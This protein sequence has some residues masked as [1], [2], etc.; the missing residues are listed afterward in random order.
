MRNRELTGRTATSSAAGKRRLLAFALLLV[1]AALAGGSY[2]APRPATGEAS[3]QAP[4]TAMPLVASA[5]V[6][7][8][9]TPLPG[10]D[11]GE[12]YFP[13]LPG[14]DPEASISVGDTSHGYLVGGTELLENEALGILPK[15][16]KRNL[17]YGSQ[18][19]VEMLQ[20]AG[21]ALYKETKTRLWVG[22]VGKRGGGDITWSV[23]HNSGRDADVAF[24]YTDRKGT[25]ID[26]PDLVALNGQ[27]LAATHNLKLDPKR[28]WIVVKALLGYERAQVQYLFVAEALKTQVLMFASQH[29]ESPAL[30]TRAAAAMAQP[31]GSAPHNDHLHLRIFCSE[32]DVLGGCTNTGGTPPG[33]NLFTAERKRFVRQTAKLLGRSTPKQ[34]K[35]AIERL[36]LLDAREA[37]AK[38]AEMLSED[39]NRPE[40]RVA[41][42]RS[43]A[44]LGGP[45]QVPTLTKHFARE[46]SPAVR[47]AITQSIGQIG[48]RDA[49]RFLARAV[50]TPQQ[51]AANVLTGVSA[52]IDLGGPTL[53]AIL[54][55]A[56][57]LSRDSFFTMWLGAA[58][59]PSEHGARRLQA[60]LVAIEAAAKSERLEPMK[61]LIALLADPRPIVRDRAAYALRMLTNLSYFTKWKDGHEALLARGRRRWQMA[62]QASKGSPRRAWLATGFLAAGY[63]VP[64]INQRR[65]WELVRAIAGPERISY[66]AQRMLMRLL[67]HNPPSL[68]WSRGAACMHW[69]KWV[70][71]RRKSFKLEK[72]P[73]KVFRAC[74][75]TR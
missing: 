55:Q 11:S 65:T 24:S 3:P 27:G 44:R 56:V 37:A 30:I 62:Y 45:S 14:E 67:K 19:L 23:S 10:A 38:I 33:T 36:S 69:F 7:K 31:H 71:G 20:I 57:S 35:R 58:P 8:E 43:L 29:G 47:I 60:Q 22:N 28:T 48:G 17:R 40:V 39:S 50:G 61:R 66:N 26:P 5:A 42:A 2:L 6:A 41:A 68:E 73:S 46:D 1:G 51:T 9:R 54:P 64:E 13:F 59:G 74:A 21:R 49:G 53:L 15:Q 25:P 16:K 18:P 4:R 72:P 34:H 12:R 75:G 52:A 32:A 70:R 63:K